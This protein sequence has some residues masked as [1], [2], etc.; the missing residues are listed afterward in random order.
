[1]AL[2]HI[3]TDYVFLTTPAVTP[4]IT[5]ILLQLL[6]Q[7]A[8][9]ALLIFQA[10]RRRAA[11][12]RMMLTVPPMVFVVTFGIMDILLGGSFLGGG[13]VYYGAL[14]DY[15]SLPNV[16]RELAVLLALFPL[17]ALAVRRYHGKK[18]WL[19]TLVPDLLAW[20]FYLFACAVTADVALHGTAT[21]W[22]WLDVPTQL[23]WY[24]Y[25]LYAVVFQFL[26]D[27]TALLWHVLF[28]ERGLKKAGDTFFY[29]PEACRKE[30]LRILLR[31]HRVALCTLGPLILFLE[32]MLFLS[33]LEEPKDAEFFS[34][35]LFI[36]VFFFAFDAALVY[37]VRHLLFPRTLPAGKRLDQWADNLPCQFCR[38]YYDVDHPPV[39]SGQLEV[40]AHF[41]V[42]GGIKP[43]LYYI[44]YL[45]S[46]TTY[47][48]GRITLVFRDGSV[49]NMNVT[50]KGQEL[51]WQAIRNCKERA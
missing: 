4:S 51:L 45:E 26:L 17:A 1:M 14:L 5:L 6:L 20:G 18:A 48:G 24:V 23:T 38:E 12:E 49:F 47:A 37:L 34:Q 9:P 43:A 15:L 22:G 7:T 32:V 40:T 10:V 39:G 25:S 50:P 21:G 3:L 31:G 27:L 11:W 41:I 42:S 8:P 46:A 16:L 2:Y 13:F 35:F 30:T 19:L 33:V 36:R 29:D 44:P 28:S